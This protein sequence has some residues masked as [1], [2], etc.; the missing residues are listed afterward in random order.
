MML[1]TGA[2]LPETPNQVTASG[3]LGCLLGASFPPGWLD[4]HDPDTAQVASAQQ[5][6]LRPSTVIA[7]Y[8]GDHHFIQGSHDSCCGHGDIASVITRHVDTA[9]PTGFRPTG[10]NS[11]RLSQHHDLGTPG[12]VDDLRN[13]EI[14]DPTTDAIAC[15]Q[16][17][18]S[19]DDQADRNSI[20]WSSRS[21]FADARRR[22]SS[23]MLG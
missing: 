9:A 8:N 12:K 19:G 13:E 6:E 7:E 14:R 2:W 21:S 18:R 10:C 16:A 4:E 5:E 15:D 17:S 20:G 1:S 3:D 23:T 22:Y 11:D